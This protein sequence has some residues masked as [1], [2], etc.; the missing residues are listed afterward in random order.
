M[1]L[2]YVRGYPWRIRHKTNSSGKQTKF[3]GPASSQL[4]ASLVLD[5]FSTLPFYKASVRIRCRIWE[6]RAYDS[7]GQEQVGTIELK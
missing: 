4:R 7:Q 1:T 3:D 2:S 6:W 5:E